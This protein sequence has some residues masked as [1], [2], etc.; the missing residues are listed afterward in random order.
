MTPLH[1]AVLEALSGGGALFF[2]DLSDR[3]GSLDD[4]ALVAALWDLVWAGRL[5]GDTLAP[6]RATLGTGRPAH[7]P[8]TDAPAAGRAADAQRPADRRGPLVAAAAPARP[9]RRSGRTRRPRRCW[10][11]TAW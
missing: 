6:L 3:V 1:E 9:T 4:A 8:R 11:G 5:S 2:R 10:N 7:R